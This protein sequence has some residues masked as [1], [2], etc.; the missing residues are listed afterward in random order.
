MTAAGKVDV[1]WASHFG[2][3]HFPLLFLWHRLDAFRDL[4]DGNPGLAFGVAS[5]GVSQTHDPGTFLEIVDDL[6]RQRRRVIAVTLGFPADAVGILAKIHPAALTERRLAL[7]RV[8]LSRPGIPDVLRHTRRIGASALEI[9]GNRRFAD[10][11]STRFLA[12]VAETDLRVPRTAARLSDTLRVM[13]Q[14]APREIPEAFQTRASLA[15]YHWQFCRRVPADELRRTL[16]YRIPPCPIQIPPDAA[17]VWEALDCAEKIVS[18]AFIQ[19]SCLA[20]P[21]LCDEIV[22]GNVYFLRSTGRWTERVTFAITPDWGPSD[23]ERIWILAHVEARRGRVPRPATVRAIKE[24][25]RR[26][27]DLAPSVAVSCYC[28]GTVGPY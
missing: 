28:P 25:L 13:E 23:R 27:Q 3:L 15:K 19:E 14:F 17:D 4:A 7:L 24:F 16:G 9:V 11:V 5:F 18:E 20:D 1:K 12:E 22:A 21:G 2:S 10:R 8:G 26:V 6:V